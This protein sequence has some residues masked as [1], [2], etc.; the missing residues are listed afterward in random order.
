MKKTSLVSAV[1]LST[2]SLSACLPAA[3]R[4]DL[5]G[6]TAQPAAATRT[7]VITRDTRYVNVEGGEIIKF[8]V[9]G[10]TFTW[11]FNGTDNIQAFDLN[12]VTPP[13]LLD[14][15]VRAYVSPNPMYLQM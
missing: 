6:Q 2:L 5:L 1:L 7:I 10:K 14:H 12:E 15:R 4:L 9:D 13:G 8:V 3:T 11:V